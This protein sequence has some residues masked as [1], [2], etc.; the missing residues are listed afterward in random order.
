MQILPLSDWEEDEDLHAHLVHLVWRTKLDDRYL[1]E[2]QGLEE[3]NYSGL[4]A[5]FD[6]ENDNK[7]I[8]VEHT[9]ISYGAP[10]GPDADDVNF[11]QSRV[12]DVVDNPENRSIELDDE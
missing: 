5:I 9:S 2:V 1:V 11:W 6:H 7:L 10:F 12:I 8:H 3:S 4:L